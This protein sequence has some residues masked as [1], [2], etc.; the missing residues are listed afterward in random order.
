[1]LYNEKYQEG[2]VLERWQCGEF[3]NDVLKNEYWLSAWTFADSWD[4]K[5]QMRN[6]ETPT[7]GSVAIIDS[8][9]HPSNWHV[10]IV[11]A[12]NDDWTVT[13]KETNW[14][15]DETIHVRDIN[16][17]WIYGYFDP[18]IDSSSA[19][20]NWSRNRTIDTLSPTAR[21]VVNWDIVLSADVL[22]MAARTEITNEIAESWINTMWQGNTSWFSLD[23]A[24]RNWDML[25]MLKTLDGVEKIDQLLK[26][27]GVNVWTFKALWQWAW[28]KIE[29]LE[30]ADFQELKTITGKNLV[31]YMKSIS[32]VAISDP[33]RR[34]LADL[35]PNVTMSD[36]KF[37]ATYK[38]FIDQLEITMQGAMEQYWFDS[39]DELRAEL[40]WEEEV[41][42]SLDEH[43]W[44]HIEE[45]K[46]NK[47]YS[48]IADE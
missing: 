15:N 4:S 38:E 24:D 10:G 26:W 40:L 13:I 47:W 3:V 39:I 20:N 41:R 18:S 42:F 5:Q 43:R 8:E 46:K 28:Q 23:A 33:E 9:T 7:I 21:D 48:D 12:I 2:K 36:K 6:S 11:T 45:E 31:S 37:A 35:L 1:M 27:D 17:S 25:N 30:D 34:M 19:T 44:V 16:T 32:W 29:F 22:W 14:N